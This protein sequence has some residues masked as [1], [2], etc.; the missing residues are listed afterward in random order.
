MPPNDSGS[1]YQVTVTQKAMSCAEATQWAQKLI[2]Q[3]VDGKPMMPSYPPPT[4]GPAGYICKGSPDNTGHAYRGHCLKQS[5]ATFAPG[6]NW[7]N[8]PTP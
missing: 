1:Q 6:F 4:G 2:A 7:T 8:H 5:T 3:H